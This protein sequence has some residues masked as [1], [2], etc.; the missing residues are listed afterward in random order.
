MNAFSPTPHPQ[1]TELDRLRR[2]LAL[3]EE[4][5]DAAIEQR[6]AARRDEVFLKIRAGIAEETLREIREIIN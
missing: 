1:E 2:Q 5:R 4:E 3:T 6:D